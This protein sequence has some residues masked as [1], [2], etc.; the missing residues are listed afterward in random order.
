MSHALPAIQTRDLVMQ[1]PA[2]QGWKS[3]FK[4]EPG[5]VVLNVVVASPLRS[6]TQRAIARAVELKT[7]GGCTMTVRAVPRIERTE[8]GKHRMM[9]QHLDI[10]RY[11]GAS[12]GPTV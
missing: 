7:Q 10:R 3:I 4:H 11:L 2:Q 6:A 8:R 9:I 12:I 1:F 5:K